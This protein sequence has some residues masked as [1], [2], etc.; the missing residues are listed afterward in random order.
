MIFPPEI[1][2]ISKNEE[3]SI[4]MGLRRPKREVI[5]CE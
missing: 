2:V 1:S 4:E 5:R 3:N